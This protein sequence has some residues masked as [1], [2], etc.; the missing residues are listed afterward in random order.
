MTQLRKNNVIMARN[1]VKNT[2]Q[3]NVHFMY[4]EGKLSQITVDSHFSF[5]INRYSQKLIEFI[6]WFV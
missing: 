2:S 6:S 1:G 3:Y 4:D 5:I